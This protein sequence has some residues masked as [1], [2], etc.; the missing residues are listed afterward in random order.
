MPRIISGTRRELSWLQ[1]ESIR[2]ASPQLQNDKE[3]VALAV[4]QNGEA[5]EYASPQLQ[6]DNLIEM[7]ATQQNPDAIKHVQFD[8]KEIQTY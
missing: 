3:V 7:V 5:L 8:L 1:S 4:Q 2:I 6:R